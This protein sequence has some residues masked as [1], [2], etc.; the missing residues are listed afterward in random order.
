MID[1]VKVA[2]IDMQQQVMAK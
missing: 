2:Q 1:Y